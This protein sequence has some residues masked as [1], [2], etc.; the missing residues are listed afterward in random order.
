MEIVPEISFNKI[1]ITF[2]NL[3]AGQL[4]QVPILVLVS[5]LR[6]LLTWTLILKYLLNFLDMHKNGLIE[7]NMSCTLP[8]FGKSYL[9]YDIDLSNFTA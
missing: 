3:S 4:Y 6:S 7:L 1:S 2:F 8:V 9:N 5:R